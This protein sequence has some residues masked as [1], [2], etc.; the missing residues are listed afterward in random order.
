MDE[1][2]KKLLEDVGVI[3]WQFRQDRKMTQ[4]EAAALAKSTQARLSDIEAGKTD[5]KLSN[6]VRWAKALGYDLQLSF[7]PIEEQP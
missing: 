2:T 4:R 3:I 5:M 1:T 6:L 7:V